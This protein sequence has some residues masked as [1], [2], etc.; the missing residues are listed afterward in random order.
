MNKKK[1]KPNLDSLCESPLETVLHSLTLTMSIHILKLYRCCNA[2]LQLC[3]WDLNESY[4]ISL[5]GNTKSM[6][7][8][9]G[10]H[11]L[12]ERTVILIG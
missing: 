5:G 10:K 1:R 3:L 7:G 6:M 8:I 9:G 2:R 4:I 12:H 11:E